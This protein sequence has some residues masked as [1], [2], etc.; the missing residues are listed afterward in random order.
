[1]ATSKVECRRRA[2][3]PAST[4][5]RHN[6]QTPQTPPRLPESPAQPRNFLKQREL[7]DEN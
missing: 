3:P 2:L 6:L 5:R 4:G 7:L 1:M